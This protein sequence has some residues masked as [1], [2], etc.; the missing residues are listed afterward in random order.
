MIKLTMD[1]TDINGMINLGIKLHGHAGPYLNLGIKMG[2]MALD[3]LNVQGY[4]DLSTEV[5]LTYHTP[6]SCLVDGLQISTGCT[7]GKGNIKVIDKTG[8][9][10]AFFKANNK[11]LR[12]TLKPCI[13]KLIDFEKESCEDLGQH[14]LNMTNAELFDHEV[15]DN[16]SM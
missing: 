6:I 14:I 12:I 3:I 8:N 10:Q 4:F 16:E 1:R 9:I 7:M 11:N 13:T 2:I 5:E 15:R